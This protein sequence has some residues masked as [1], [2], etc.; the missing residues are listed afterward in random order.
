[1]Y[2]TLT[3]FL[4]TFSADHSFLWALLVVAVVAST[5]LLLF[6]F[7]ETVLRLLSSGGPVSKTAGRRTK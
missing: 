6:A 3:D 7:W 2:D 5:S 4:R 1:M